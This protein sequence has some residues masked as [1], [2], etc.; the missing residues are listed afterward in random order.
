[1]ERLKGIF[2]TGGQG[3]LKNYFI[4]DSSFIYAKTGSM[5]NIAAL[6]GY[7]ITKKGKTLIFSIIVNN[8]ITN[9][10]PVRR[11]IESFLQQI[12]NKY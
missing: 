7:L 2:P 1:M 4:S 5:S 6:S 11:A 9:A 8:Y 12:R 3:S 10:Y